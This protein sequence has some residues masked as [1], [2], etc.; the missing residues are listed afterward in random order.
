MAM[1]AELQPSLRQRIELPTLLVALVI[2]G[3]Y[4]LLTL[5][6]TRLPPALAVPL[7]V[8]LI[9][10]YGSLQHEIIHGHPTPSQGFN[11]LLGFLPLALWLPYPIYRR[12]HLVHHR[13]GGRILTDPYDDPESYYLPAGSDARLDPVR[14]ALFR[15]NDTLPGRL[16]VGPLLMVTRFFSGELRRLARGD[17]RYLGAWLWHVAGVA[18]VLAWTH[19]VCHIPVAVY[20]GLVVYPSISLSMVRS[21]AEH[22]ADPDPA[23]R[24]AVVEANVFWGLLF[25]YNNLHIV[26]HALPRLPWYALPAQWRQMRDGLPAA[27]ARRAGMVYPGGYLEIA[28]RYLLRPVISVDH[29]GP[30]STQ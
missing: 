6:F 10:W 28:R 15:F 5:G 2:L 16:I 8:V 18:L 1:T 27:R 22:R 29:P 23:L 12:T 17:T 13:A 3:G 20:L 19:L 21:F 9:A 24:T 11:T 4:G 30:A 25:L 26:H 7:L 14:R